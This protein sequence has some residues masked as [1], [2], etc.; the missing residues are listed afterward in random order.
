VF[1][2]SPLREAL[3]QADQYGLRII[4]MKRDWRTVFI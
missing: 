1:K 2:L 4:S 3:Y